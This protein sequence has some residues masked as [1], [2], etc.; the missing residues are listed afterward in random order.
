M[1]PSP[2]PSAAKQR[3][4]AIDTLKCVAAMMVVVLHYGYLTVDNAAGT[5]SFAVN[6]LTRVAVPLFFMITG[7]YFVLSYQRGQLKRQVKRLCSLTVFAIVLYAAFEVAWHLA[8]GK[9]NVLAQSFD[10]HDNI[11]TELSKILIFNDIPV[12]FHLWYLPAA[13]YALGAMWAFERYKLWS[14]PL[15]LFWVLMFA[16]AAYMSGFTDIAYPYVRNF[17]TVAIPSMVVGR[18]LYEH[19]A[20]PQA[21]QMSTSAIFMCIVVA[22]V[23]VAAQM[24]WHTF[25]HGCAVSSL[26]DMPIGIPFLATSLMLLALHFPMLGTS[27]PLPAIG[28]K[29]SGYIYVFHVI[30]GTVLRTWFHADSYLTFLLPFIVFAIALVMAVVWVRIRSSLSALRLP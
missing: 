25:H 18:C 1:S 23:M 5:L 24:G 10:W 30:P 22:I 27:T 4:S 15:A 20:T 13:I 28:A 26:V 11:L 29:Y 16:V 21:R 2:A 9:F 19:Y 6:G 3:D 12:A 8:I 17:I 14:K 7:F